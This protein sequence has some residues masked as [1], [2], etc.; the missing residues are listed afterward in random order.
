VDNI[1]FVSLVSRWLH[2]LAATTAVGGT[3]FS[4]FAL[5]PAVGALADD[6]RSI[7][8]EGI[9]TRWSKFVAAS[10][11]F[12]LVSGLYNF[13]MIVRS[14]DLPKPYHM[15]FGIKFILAFVIFMVASLLSGR[16][17]LAK[18]V[19]ANARLWLNVNVALAVVVICLSGVLRALPH[20]P[21]EPP[22][23]QS[24]LDR[25]P[26]ERNSLPG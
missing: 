12:L 22:A 1:D 18:R 11:L 16:T 5:L 7:L 2:I 9:R 19:R 4:R 20:A 10:I 13:M 14:Y 6:Q 24:Q 25:D 26:A 15:L 23:K 3:I 17:E 21:K 8:M